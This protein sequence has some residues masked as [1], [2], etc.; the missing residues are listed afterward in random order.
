MKKILASYADAYGAKI[1]LGPVY[2]LAYGF[3]L[4]SL[5][6]ASVNQLIVTKEIVQLRCIVLS[7]RPESG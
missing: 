4:L 7:P 3:Q 2:N 1:K 6:F 5:T